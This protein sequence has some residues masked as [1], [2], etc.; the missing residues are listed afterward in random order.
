M[1][2]QNRLLR[3]I[4]EKADSC[5]AMIKGNAKEPVTA[6]LRFGH[7]VVVMP[8]VCSLNLN[9]FGTH[10]ANTDMLEQNGWYSYRMFPMASNVQ[11]VFYLAPF[12]RHNYLFVFVYLFC[13]FVGDS[14]FYHQLDNA[15]RFLLQNLA[16]RL[17]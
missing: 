6:S 4:V 15:S 9:G 13:S 11:I 16:T 7:E 14:L 5:L 3:N 8:L 12:F 1:M 10:Y 17:C 2:R